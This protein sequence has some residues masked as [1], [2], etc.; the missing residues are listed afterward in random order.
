MPYQ[1]VKLYQTG[2]Y[3][4]GGRLLDPEKRAVQ[5]GRS[6]PTLSPA[7]TAPV[8]AAVRRSARAS[9]STRR[10]VATQGKLIAA[11]AT[12][13]LEVFSTP[14]PESSWQLPWIHSPLRQR[15]GGEHRDRRGAEGQGP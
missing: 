9:C 2:T 7:G 11:N 10:C 6:A 14:Y 12:G 1:D 3:A 5:A 15:P 13:C 4:V 8:R